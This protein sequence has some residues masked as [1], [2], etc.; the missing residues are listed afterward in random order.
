ML[1]HSGVHR[2]S[3][4]ASIPSIGLIAAPPHRS[5]NSGRHRG[6]ALPLF[7][8]GENSFTRTATDDST[9]ADTTYR[10]EVSLVAG[11]QGYGRRRGFEPPLRRLPASPSGCGPQAKW[12]KSTR[13]PDRFPRVSP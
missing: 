9:S 8:S 11:F 10:R 7:Q 12:L 6:E 2:A 3:I 13:G 4:G 5:F 1:V